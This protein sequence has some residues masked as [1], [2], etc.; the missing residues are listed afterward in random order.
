M[1][2]GRNWRQ[3]L[4][5]I[6]TPDYEVGG[7]PVFLAMEVDFIYAG[8]RLG[9]N[10]EIFEPS[11]SSMD[12]GSIRWVLHFNRGAY[13]FKATFLQSIVN[14]VEGT[15]YQLLI[16]DEFASVLL[17]IWRRLSYQTSW[18]LT[19]APPNICQFPVAQLSTGFFGRSFD[20]RVRPIP[21]HEEP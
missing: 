8:G 1:H 9:I 16:E 19:Y 17:V 4:P 20:W 13:N 7:A 18:H 15:H 14:N 3:V 12:D 10:D 5:R 6:I 21:Y 11:D 2:K